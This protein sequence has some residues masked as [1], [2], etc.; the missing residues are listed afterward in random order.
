MSSV[1]WDSGVG[2]DSM[3]EYA[4]TIFAG[5]AVATVLGAV[6]RRTTQSAV[7]R[8]DVTAYVDE[9]IIHILAQRI[10]RGIEDVRAVLLGGGRPEIAKKLADTR[11][12]AAVQFAKRDK[13]CVVRVVVSFPGAR[14]VRERE[15]DWRDVPDTVRNDLQRQVKTAVHRPW[16]G[17]WSARAAA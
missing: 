7:E 17:L 5:A 11:W 13:G 15:V 10:G 3:I 16:Q 12:F 9:Q 4:E 1:G 8:A 2:G 14:V 6:L